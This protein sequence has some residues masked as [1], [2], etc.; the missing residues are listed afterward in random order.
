MRCG[1]MATSCYAMP[2]HRDVKGLQAELQ[3]TVHLLSDDF[4]AWPMEFQV[5]SGKEAL[6][7]CAVAWDVVWFSCAMMWCDLMRY[8]TIYDK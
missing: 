8:I 5:V 4:K 2:L 1:V 6:L 7:I 3:V